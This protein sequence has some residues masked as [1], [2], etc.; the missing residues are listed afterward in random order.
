[1]SAFNTAIESLENLLNELES[2]KFV[3]EIGRGRY[4]LITSIISRLKG[5]CD[6]LQKY[7]TDDFMKKPITEEIARSVW[8]DSVRRHMPKTGTLSV[9]SED[10]FTTACDDVRLVCLFVCLLK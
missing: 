1:M 9:F 5:I 4:D 3:S 6:D 2:Q 7:I 10:S 8:N